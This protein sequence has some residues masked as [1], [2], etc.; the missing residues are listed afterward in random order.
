MTRLGD[1]GELGLLRSLGP[2][3]EKRG[4]DLLIGPGE[5]DAA[6]W[7]EADGTITVA[8]TDAFVE[9]VHFD[10][11]WLTAAEVGWRSVALTA[12]DLAA[13]GATPTYGLVTVAA[14]PD[15]EE[16]TLVALYAGLA[17]MAG[18]IGLRLV[19][20]DMTATSGP[21]A[22]SVTAL[23]RTL[24]PVVPRSAARPG[25]T[26]AV[27]G[28]LGA[29]AAGLEAAIA[30]R[31]LRPAW[32]A[33]LRRPRPRLVEGARLAAAGLSCGDIS[34]GLVREMEKFA[35][36]SGCGCRLRMP[37]VPIAAGVGVGTA[38]TGG[39]EMELVC[40]GPEEVVAAAVAE[41]DR[42]LTVVGEMT[43]EPDVIVVN[44]DG[45]QLAIGRRGYDHF[46]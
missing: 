22:I 44:G 35:F 40:A 16:D 34:D 23:G 2:L 43:E 17:E 33:A 19:G 20:G 26:V 14:P 4:G 1:I 31:P 15:W 45:K 46:G 32:E 39:E 10:F 18:E 8:T 27:T 29:A 11:G 3:L 7:R 41:M 30:H 5:D 6:A 25:W 13:K 24:G 38:L 42:L 28:R 37:W 12:S 21:A 9:R 36:A